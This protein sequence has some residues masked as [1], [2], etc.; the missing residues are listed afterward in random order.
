MTAEQIVD[1][2]FAA[3]GKEFDAEILSLDPEGR[4]PVE[5]FLN[6]GAPRRAWEFTSLSNERDRPAL[7]LPMSQ[8]IVD[9]LVSF[10]WRDSRPN[11]ISERE[12]TVTVLQPLSLANGV[13]GARVNRLSDDSALT[14]LALEDQTAGE[15]IE[16]VYLRLLSR[17]AEQSERDLFLDLLDD[18]YSDRRVPGAKPLAKIH[19][20]V[21]NVSWANHLSAEATR[22]MNETER[23]VR[24]GDPPT[25]LLEKKWR[26]RMEDMIWALT[27][28][29]EFV[30]LP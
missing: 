19:R 8:S 28:S 23:R 27:N 29:P 9:V 17:P 15:L 5:T 3:A 13:V 4:R 10:G 7:A 21:T 2:L 25:P 1:S 30:F 24:A 16:D 14:A 22:I 12:E 20:H 11:P 6:L 26:E 18:G